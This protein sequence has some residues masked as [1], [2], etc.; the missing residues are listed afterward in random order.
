MLTN[1]FP[2][3]V[4]GYAVRSQEIL[5]AQ[6]QIDLH[7]TAI[8][9]LAYPVNVGRFPQADRD[10]VADVTYAR[11]LPRLYP[12]TA[13]NQTRLFARLIAEEAERQSASV[14]HTTTPWPNAAA[15]SLAAKW[16][17]IPWVYEVR[18]V[19]EITWAVSQPDANRAFDSLFYRNS[20]QKEMQAMTAA[21]AIVALSQTVERNLKSRGINNKIVIVPNSADQA[22]RNEAKNPRT[23]QSLLGLPA[24]R[25]VGAVSSLVDYEGFDCLIRAISFLPRDV[26]VLLVGD[27]LALP[28]LRALAQ[29]L[30]VADRVVF[31]GRKTSSEIANWYSAL[32]VF[33]AP[34][35]NNQLTRLVTPM[36]TVRAQMH[37]TPVVASDLPALREVTQN[38]AVY[39]KA[40]D[41]KDLARAINEV[42]S[43]TKSSTSCMHLPTWAD[44]AE[45]Y[46]SLYGS[47]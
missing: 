44:S 42:L 11:A 12:L 21:S 28:S 40:E 14:L 6:N 1:S 8:T 4:G 32:D 43:E 41:S 7:S 35:K 37:G 15:T 5:R 19:P 30:E 27:G 33:V 18:G 34:R 26:R 39:A 29:E 17:N 13:V 25:Y 2:Y 47:L 22:W 9:R 45:V 24:G 23:A 10:V 16:L 20:R 36:K 31:A 3:S 46:R 38:K